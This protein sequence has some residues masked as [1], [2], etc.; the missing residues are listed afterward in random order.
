MHFE[1][2]GLIGD[3]QDIDG[4]GFLDDVAV[5]ILDDD[6]GV[7]L[8]VRGQGCLELLPLGIFKFGPL[9]AA[10]AFRE[11]GA[12]QPWSSLAVAEVE[13]LLAFCLLYTSPSPRD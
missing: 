6:L 1:L 11:R 12:A 4:R 10:A 2:V 8:L 7:R 5:E 13:G 9:A 3:Q